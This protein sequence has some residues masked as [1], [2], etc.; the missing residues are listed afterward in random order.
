[1]VTS[2]GFLEDISMLTL[3][4]DHVSSSDEATF[5]VSGYVYSHNAR[6]RAALC[7]HVFI[8]EERD[9]S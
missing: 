2:L 3:F 8:E 6:I 4:L 5:H 9:K 7:P 1:M